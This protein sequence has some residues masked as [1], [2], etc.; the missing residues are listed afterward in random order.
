MSLYQIDD[1]I[2]N[3]YLDGD[4]IELYHDDKVYVFG[5]QNEKYF[6]EPNPHLV[7]KARLIT[8]GIKNIIN[9]LDLENDNLVLKYIGDIKPYLE[10]IVIKLVVGLPLG[11]RRMFKSDEEN[12]KLNIVIDVTNNLSEEDDIDLYLSDFKD[13]IKYAIILMVLDSQGPSDINDGYT[14]LTHGI[15]ASS[16]ACYISQSRQLELLD[17]INFIQMIESDE[18]RVLKQV[19]KANKKSNVSRYISLVVQTNPEMIILGITGKRFLLTLEDEQ[20]LELFKL[21]AE[22]FCNAIVESKEIKSRAFL[23]KMLKVL[24][25]I[26]VLAS[27]ILAGLFVYSLFQGIT[28]V[29]KVFVLVYLGITLLKNFVENKLGLISNKRFLIYVGIISIIAV[30]YILIML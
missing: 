5:P 30:F 15:Y 9:S 14:T 8:E 7:N 6:I 18:Y 13:F 23:P 20:V 4:D 21:G 1:R 10:N 2:I 17:N 11:Y 16:F 3:H 28:V 26:T 24:N 19:I 22:A 29:L 25:R 12:G 27:A